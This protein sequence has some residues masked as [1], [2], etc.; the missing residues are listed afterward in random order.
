MTRIDSRENS[1]FQSILLLFLFPCPTALRD[2]S[3]HIDLGY[4]VI[5][6]RVWFGTTLFFPAFVPGV[7]EKVF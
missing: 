4:G 3:L 5:I 7:G 6:I 2:V 1:L